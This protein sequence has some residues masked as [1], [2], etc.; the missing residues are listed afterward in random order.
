[1]K[2]SVT[3]QCGVYIWI[4]KQSYKTYIGAAKDQ[5]DR[6]YDHTG[7]QSSNKYLKRL[8]TCYGD[9]GF[10]LAILW[11]A[12][13]S[14]EVNSQNVYNVEMYYFQRVVP[15]DLLLNA[16]TVVEGEYRNRPFTLA[17]PERKQRTSNRMA[18]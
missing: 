7:S 13:T 18:W 5:T 4:H 9:R 3:G 14:N 2:K 16:D 12:G 17:K 11:I 8:K 6:P 15:G 1:M 10:Y